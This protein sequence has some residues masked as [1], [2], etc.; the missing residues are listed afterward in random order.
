MGE[1]GKSDRAH[2]CAARAGQNDAC[3]MRRSAALHVR[4]MHAQR[5]GNATRSGATTSSFFTD[6]FFPLSPSDGL[7]L[8]S[9][10]Q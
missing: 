7:Y 4:P 5:R 8:E 9:Y 10:L 2:R 3:A 6:Y 1:C